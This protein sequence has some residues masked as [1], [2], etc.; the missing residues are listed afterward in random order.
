MT[1]VTPGQSAMRYV[2]FSSVLLLICVHAYSQ[3]GTGSGIPATFPRPPVSDSIPVYGYEVI[4]SFPHDPDAFTQGLIYQNGALYEGTG[5][6]GQSTLRKVDLET[7]TV[8]KIR[9]LNSGYFGEGVTIFEDRILQLT[10]RSGIGFVYIEEANFTLV[11]S[12]SYATEGWGFTHDDTSLIMSDGTSRI[13][14]LDPDTYSEIGHID[15]RAGGQ[16]VNELNE[17][18]YIQGRIY[19]NIWYSDYIAIIEPSTGDVVG[20][21]DMTGLQEKN[22]TDLQSDVLNGIAY[23]IDGARLFVT[24][25]LWPTLFEVVVEPLEYP[26]VITSSGPPSPIST[27]LDSTITMWVHAEDP[28]QE[29][30]LVFSWSVNGTVDTSAHDTSYSYSSSVPAVDTVSVLAGDGTFTDSTSWIVYVSTV[31][32]EGDNPGESNGI[33]KIAGLSQN[34]P[35]PFNPV[36]TIPFEIPGEPGTLH[37]VK[38]TI[39]DIRGRLVRTL[40]DSEAKPGRTRITWDG[41]SDHSQSAASGVYICTLRYDDRVSTRKLTIL[42]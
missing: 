30:S 29:D 13:Y 11:N 23:D 42:R 22:R 37:H 27:G 26:P 7:G 15:V 12:F 8:L 41:K 40:M 38:L 39:H 5:L 21:L 2:L 9:S 6:Y 16:P 33:V 25:K 18:E 24:G 10:W 4:H 36:T 19:A 17:L 28:D 34:Y 32:I 3:T 35:N 1:A 31:G 20:W 14:Y